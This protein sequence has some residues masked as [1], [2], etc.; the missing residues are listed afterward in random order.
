MWSGSI[1]VVCDKKRQVI[2]TSLGAR[3]LHVHHPVGRG[4][5]SRRES[6]AGPQCTVLPSLRLIC[7]RPAL[8]PVCGFWVFFWLRF[9]LRSF[10][11]WRVCAIAPSFVSGWRAFSSVSLYDNRSPSSILLTSSISDLAWGLF[12]VSRHTYGLVP[13]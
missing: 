13:Y 2:Q 12:V 5:M 7:F 9:A 8:S 6:L 11:L 1:E 4:R 3:W 10:A